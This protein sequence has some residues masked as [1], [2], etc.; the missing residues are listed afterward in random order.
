MKTSMQARECDRLLTTRGA[1]KF[2]AVSPGTLDWWRN[3]LHSGPPFIKLN[4]K[5]GAVRYLLSDLLAW[6]AARRVEPESVEGLRLSEL[7]QRVRSEAAMAKVPH[8]EVQGVRAQGTE[9]R[10]EARPGIG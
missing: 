6:V 5:K 10:A 8:V 1:A 4:G 3:W 2:L 7:R 9:P